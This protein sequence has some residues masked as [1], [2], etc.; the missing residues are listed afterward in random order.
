MPRALLGA[1]LATVPLACSTVPDRLRTASL[2]GVPWMLAAMLAFASHDALAKRMLETYG[3][4][5]LLLI[6]GA[7][8]FLTIA[9]RLHH[10]GW[11]R[12]FAARRWK[13]LLVRVTLIVGDIA[14]FYAAVRL[15][16]LAECLTIY[17]AMPL[18]AAALAAIVLSERVGAGR[19]AA[20]VAG[21]AGVVLVMRPGADGI[22]WP[23]LLALA[24]TT[25]Y[26]FA[27]VLTRL[28][29]GEGGH[30]LIA[31]QT[32]AIVVAGIVTAPFGW[33]P[34]A[35]PDLGLV[36]LLGVITTTGN[37][38]FIRSLAL[39]PASVV[40]PFHYSIIVWGLVF[41]WAVWRDVPDLQMLLGAA[42]VVASG[43]PIVLGERVKGEETR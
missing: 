25:I 6:G 15:M 27:N 31:W 14:I 11:Q 4:A 40:L 43:V 8:G 19:W 16:P 42:I 2:A 38:F 22:A 34:M 29:A 10:H 41:G 18:I 30:T 23:A 24:G 7:A 26:A 39:S 1:S 33:V 17:Q 35:W 12:S 32:A 28:L 3:I 36:A 20:I 21:F 37:V 13:L 5:Q 9:P